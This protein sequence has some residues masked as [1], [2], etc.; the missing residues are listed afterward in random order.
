MQSY[1]II[2]LQELSTASERYCRNINREMG[3]DAGLPVPVN[4]RATEEDTNKDDPEIK[5]LYLIQ[6]EGF[7]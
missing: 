7:K 6:E 5:S 4:Q 2:R 1:L 3:D